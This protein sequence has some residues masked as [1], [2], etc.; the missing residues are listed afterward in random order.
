MK[1]AHDTGPFPA[2]SPANGPSIELAQALARAFAEGK[3]AW[4]GVVVDERDFARYLTD[5]LEEGEPGASALEGLFAAD[6]YLTCACA[7][8]SA[9]AIE[10]FS[11]RLLADLPRVLSSVGAAPIADDV[12]QILLE[13]LFVGNAESPPKIGTY[14]GRGQLAAWV[15]VA[16]VRIAM[17][18]RRSE[19]PSSAPGPD[20][21]LDSLLPS[22][23]P[24]LDALKLRYAAIFNAAL[25]DAF[26]ALPPRDRTLLK[27]HYVD[28]IPV[29]RIASSYN[30][31]RV[32]ASRWLSAAR[33]RVLEE[34]VRL[35]RERKH[36]T[37]SEYESLARLVQSQLEVSLGSAVGDGGDGDPGATG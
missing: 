11:R 1:R 9:A 35:V 15:R 32:S 10:A 14:S 34:T 2:A 23:D 8:G 3:S 17:S 37:E 20:D 18:L 28:R 4:P 16:A 12:R 19:H 5:R 33:S 29:D 6:L 31:H 30:A 27:L 22:V 7:S 26:A 21:T 36:L 25:K 24:E 13:R